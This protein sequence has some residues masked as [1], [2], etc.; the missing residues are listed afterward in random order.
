MFLLSS[1][2]C[3]KAGSSVRAITASVGPIACGIDSAGHSMTLANG[4]KNSLFA[5]G[6]SHDSQ[7]M[8]VGSNQAHRSFCTNRGDPRLASVISVAP[9]VFNPSST[10][11]FNAT[12]TFELAKAANSAFG[13]SHGR[14]STLAN[15]S[16]N[17]SAM[18]RPWRGV[19]T[20][21]ALMQLRPP[22]AAIDSIMTSRCFSQ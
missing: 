20:P 4:N 1:N 15:R 19:H 11:L 5:N 22:F 12:A 3:V 18:A 16:A 9:G 10:M 6:W 8:I 21:D 17:A 2:D 13:S 14:A 7:Y